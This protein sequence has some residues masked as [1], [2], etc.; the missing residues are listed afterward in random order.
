MSGRWGLPDIGGSWP[1]G[2]RLEVGGRV[3]EGRF[4]MEKLGAAS[5]QWMAERAQGE[6]RAYIYHGGVPLPERQLI[7]RIRKLSGKKSLIGDDCAVLE[8][9]SGHELLVTTDLCLEGVHFRRDW[10]PAESVGHRCLAR[11]LSDI[12]AMAGEPLACFLSLGLP[13]DIP[14]KWVDRFLAGFTDLA[15]RFDVP[16]AGGD[17]GESKSGIVADVILVGS[18]PKGKAVR[19]SGA[20]PGDLIYVTGELGGSAATLQRLLREKVKASKASRHFYPQPRIAVAR[21]LRGIATSMIDLSDGLST[22]LAHICEESGVGAELEATRIPVTTGATLRDALHGGE[23]YELLFTAS[24]KKPVAA[25]ATRVSVR[26]IGRVTHDRRQMMW[27]KT[28]D[29]KRM[30]MPVGGWEHFRK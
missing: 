20:K 13:V 28:P 27:L 8:P 15:R 24:E 21:K 11:G 19:R 2:R 26:R 23:D 6:R 5:F 4:G 18:A 14:Q 17:T 1:D 3:R 22:D 10:H 7:A 30:P 29:G 25:A 12:A 9:P 16:L